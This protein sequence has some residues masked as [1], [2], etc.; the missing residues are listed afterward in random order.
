MSLTKLLLVLWRI[1]MSILLN[2]IVKSYSKLPFSIKYNS[3][4]HFLR[5]MATAATTNIKEPPAIIIAKVV[6]SIDL[7]LGAVVI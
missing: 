5:D 7:G 3:V 2:Y 1:E 4:H 6:L